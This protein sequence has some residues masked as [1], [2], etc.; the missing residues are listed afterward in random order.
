MAKKNILSGA[1]D[2][3]RN[4]ANRVQPSGG[5]GGAPSGTSSE[6]TK[7]YRQLLNESGRGANGGTRPTGIL[8][9]DDS[10]RRGY[11]RGNAADQ[12]FAGMGRVGEEIQGW[13]GQEE[14]AETDTKVD[15]ALSFLGGLVTGTVSAP[16][17]GAAQI[18]EGVTGRRATEMTDDGL[19]PEEDLGWGQRAA[20]TG[21]GAINI[22]GPMFGGSGEMLKG[23]KNALQYGIGRMAANDGKAWGTRMM[24]NAVKSAT[25]EG[26]E[27]FA[28]KTAKDMAEE[29]AEEF[30]QSPLDEIREGTIDGDW[31]TRAG[32][33]AAM[34]ALG[35]G[36]MSAAGQGINYGLSKLNPP[37]DK[38]GTR[39]TIDTPTP[40]GVLEQRSASSYGFDATKADTMLP[41]ARDA[42]DQAIKDRQT[43]PG[44]APVLQVSSGRTH[45]LNNASIGARVFRDIFYNPDR[46]RSAQMVSDWFGVSLDEMSKIMAS[47]DYDQR[48]HDL[49]EE[50][51]RANKTK[52]LHLGRNPATEKVGRFDVDVDEILT[53]DKAFIDMHPLAYNFV[54]ADVD[55]D[56]I[57]VFL[58]PS[59]TTE[60]YITRRIQNKVKNSWN[61]KTQSYDLDSNLEFED[62]SYIARDLD[63]NLLADAF[64]GA[65]S[66]LDNMDQQTSDDLVERWV[67]LY[68]RLLKGGRG[69]TDS[70]MARFFAT[71]RRDVSRMVNDESNQIAGSPD[72]VTSDLIGSLSSNPV[73]Q[74]QHA[75][76]T[77]TN[78]VVDNFNAF[79][80]QVED[81]GGT[82]D[83]NAQGYTSRG[84]LPS[85]MEGLVTIM[86]RLTNVVAKF[87]EGQKN[88]MF[89]SDGQFVMNAQAQ[90]LI[91]VTNDLYTMLA[92]SV[93]GG[94]NNTVFDRLFAIAIKQTESGGEIIDN[95][96]SAFDGLVRAKTTLD[97]L[98]KTGGNLS[99]G[100]QL[101]LFLEKF[102]DNWN[103]MI[104]PYEEAMKS[105]TTQFPQEAPNASHKKKIDSG[106]VFKNIELVRNVVESF[107][108]INMDSWIDTTDA[109]GIQNMTIGQWLDAYIVGG[110]SDR[111][112]FGGYDP[113]F[114]KFMNLAIASRMAR[115]AGT[116]ASI[117]TIVGDISKQL[118]IL[119]ASGALDP[120][121]RA[122][123]E[124]LV[125]ALRK[126]FDPQI[127]NAV[128]LVSIDNMLTGEWGRALASGSKDEATNA[129]LSMALS[130]K[131][132]EV[133]RMLHRTLELIADGDQIAA[134]NMRLRAMS[135]L[136]MVMHMSTLDRII[137]SEIYQVARDL[138]SIRDATTFSKT[139]DALT[140]MDMSYEAKV[141]AFAIDHDLMS[142]NL[143]VDALN[144]DTN[145]LG[146]SGIS[147]KRKLAE[148][149]Y[150]MAMKASYRNNATTWS[151]IRAHAES[152]K[153]QAN[154]A[155]AIVDLLSDVY[156]ENTMDVL[157]GNIYTSL[158]IANSLKEKGL[159]PYGA[160]ME[161]QQAEI[162]M[163]GAVYSFVDKAMGLAS[164]Q[165]SME[166]LQA[167]PMKL[168]QIIINKDASIRV[169]DQNTQKDCVLTRKMI[170]DELSGGHADSYDLDFNNLDKIFTAFPQ[171]L[172][173]VPPPVLT[174]TMESS[175]S[176]PTVSQQSQ[177]PILNSIINRVGQFN[178]LDRRTSERHVKEGDDFIHNINRKIV[179]SYVMGDNEFPAAI[180]YRSGGFG[181]NA[182]LSKI[183]QKITSVT[184]DVV[185]AIL[186]M[187]TDPKGLDGVNKR[188]AEVDVQG[189]AH[190]LTDI[191][192]I[193]INSDAM[194]KLM[195]VGKNLS[196][197]VCSSMDANFQNI[198][199][200]Q[201]VAAQIRNMGGLSD[202]NRND[203]ISAIMGGDI[204][205][206]GT[207]NISVQS[208]DISDAIGT[209]MEIRFMVDMGI[210]QATDMMNS[211]SDAMSQKTIDGIHSVIDGI[212]SS[213][214]TDDQKKKLKDSLNSP[215]SLEDYYL[216][217]Y[218]FYKG[219]SEK[220]HLLTY[221]D[222]QMTKDKKAQIDRIKDERKRRNEYL[223]E[224]H[225]LAGILYEK[226]LYVDRTYRFDKTSRELSEKGKKDLRD[227]IIRMVIDLN[228]DNNS[229]GGRKAMADRNDLMQ[230]WNSF[231]IKGRLE[232]IAWRSKAYYNTN[233]VN[234]YTNDMR[235]IKRMVIGAREELQ[236]QGRAV[237]LGDF[238]IGGERPEMPKAD[239]ADPI[240]GFMANRCTVNTTRGPAAMTVGVNGAET[241]RL[242]P[243]GLVSRNVHSDVPPVEMSYDMIAAEVCRDN[244][245]ANPQKYMST[246]NDNPADLTGWNRFIGAHYIERGAFVPSSEYDVEN[247]QYV[248]KRITSDVLDDLKNHPDKK[249]LIFD[250]VMSPN[251]ID[252]ESTYDTYNG[253]MNSIRILSEIGM[254]EDTSQ[255][256]LALKTSKSTQQ[257]HRI[258][259]RV[260]ENPLASNPSPVDPTKAQSREELRKRL[261]EA[262]VRYRMNYKTYLMQVFSDQKYKVLGM[263]HMQAFDIAVLL[264]PYYEVMMSDGSRAVISTYD[265]FAGDGSAFM[266]RMDSL[267]QNGVTAVSITPM[268][269]NPKTIASRIGLRV[270]D[271]VIRHNGMPPTDE[272]DE[273]AAEAVRSWDDYGAGKL[274]ASEILSG[275]GTRSLRNTPYVIGDDNPTPYNKFISEVMGEDGTDMGLVFDASS[276]WEK[277]V[278]PESD[279]NQSNLI[280]NINKKL[281]NNG[282][283]ALGTM[284]TGDTPIDPPLIVQAFGTQAALGETHVNNDRQRFIGTLAPLDNPK[285]R[286]IAK[287]DGTSVG[288]VFHESALADAIGWAIRFRQR[289]LI[290]QEVLEKAPS[291]MLANVPMS[292]NPIAYNAGANHIYDT[293]YA[294]DPAQSKEITRAMSMMASGAS[295]RLDHNHI[296]LSVFD[297]TF[298]LPDAA[299]WANLDTVSG[300]GI[301]TSPSSGSRERELFR[302]RNLT[303]ME[304]CDAR[305]VAELKTLVDQKSVALTDVLVLSGVTDR[306]ISSDEAI[307]SVKAF[308]D[309]MSREGTSYRTTAGRG[310]TIALVK[311]TDHTGKT[312][313][314]PLIIEKNQPTYI[315]N[316]NVVDTGLGEIAWGGTSRAQ[317]TPDDPM[318]IKTY[319]A[320]Y[321]SVAMGVPSTS[322]PIV[323]VMIGDEQMRADFVSNWSTYQGRVDDFDM[324]T[325][326]DNL[327]YGYLRFGGSAFWQMSNGTRKRNP[328]LDSLTE[329]EFKGL[330]NND[331]SVWKKVQ[332]GYIKFSN[333]E[334][335]NSLVRTV[336][337]NC[338]LA[339]IPPSYVFSSITLDEGGSN[340]SL[341][342]MDVTYRLVLSG[343]SRT[344]LLRFFHLL[345]PWLCPGV[346]ADGNV[347]KTTA[348]NTLLNEYGQ[349]GI[350]V[351][352]GR[353]NIKLM[354]MDC[355]IGPGL[356]LGHSTQQTRQGSSAR[357]SMQAKNRGGLETPLTGR[358]SREVIASIAARMGNK[359]AYDLLERERISR[360][361]SRIERGEDVDGFEPIS[362]DSVD[363][364][365]SSYVIPGYTP[366]TS[367]KEILHQR[368]MLE[369]AKSFVSPPTIIGLDRK[370]IH[371]YR[372][373][374]GTNDPHFVEKNEIHS[375]RERLEKALNG[376][377]G[378]VSLDWDHFIWAVM[379]QTGMTMNGGN[380]DYRLT[381]NDIKRAVDQ[382]C[383]TLEG[384]SGLLIAVDPNSVNLEDRYQIPMLSPDMASYFMRFEAINSKWGVDD[385]GRPTS[386]GMAAF[387][388]AM[389]NE[390]ITAKGRIEQIAANGKSGHS[391]VKAKLKRDALLKFL[392]WTMHEN[393]LPEMSQHIYGDEYVSDLICNYNEFWDCIFGTPELAEARRVMKEE[394]SR[395]HQHIADLAKLRLAEVN[396][397]GTGAGYTVG[398]KANELKTI[399]DVLDYLT[400]VSQLLAV[401]SPSVMGSNIIDKGIH[402]NLT[403]LALMVGRNIG[404]GPYNTD[405]A[406]DQD[407]VRMAAQNPFLQKVFIGY[408][409]A[410]I[411]GDVYDF[412]NACT[413][414]QRLDEWMDAKR[415]RGNAFTRFSDSVF[416]LMNGG[417]IFMG[418][419]LRNFINYFLIIERDAGHDWWFQKFD[420]TGKTLIESQLTGHNPQDFLL[421]VLTGRN[422]NASFAN[423]QVAMNFALQGD[424]AQRNV[425]SMIYSE[426]IRRHG[427][428]VKFLTSTLVSRFFQY[429]TNQMGRTLQ[430]VLPMSSINYW[431]TK[432]VAENTEIGQA[433]HV[434]DAQVFTDFKR[435]AQN[436]VAHMAPVWVG[437]ILA[438]MVGLIQPPPDEEKWGN[439]EEWL[440]LGHR[441]TLDWELEDILGLSLPI[442]AFLKSCMLGNP[443]IDILVNGIGQAC[444]NN[445]LAKASDIVAMLGDEEGS[446]ISDYESDVERYADA[447]GGAPS[448]VEWLQGKGTA[449]ALTYVGQF[450]TPGFV[451]EFV[452]SPMEHSYNTIWEE[453][454]TG[455][456][457]EE[458]VAG[459]VM[460]TT[461]QDAQIR[462]V[463]RSNPVLGWI[464]DWVTH[465]NTSYTEE[466]MP[467]TKYYDPY[468]MEQVRQYSILDE[469]GNELPYEIQEARIAEI[470][471]IL[472]S[473]DDME[474]LYQSGFYLDYATWDAVGDTIW[475]IIVQLDDNYYQL[476]E[477]GGLNWEVLGEGDTYGL[478]QQRAQEITNAYYDERAYWQSLY[479]DKLMSEPMR[480]KWPVYNRY[481]T[482]YATDDNGDV[483][484]TGYRANTGFLASISPV[485]VAPG[486][487]T[488]PDGTMGYEGDWE[489]ESVAAPGQSTGQRALI[490]VEQGHW[491]YADLE[492]HAVNDDGTGYSKRRNGERSESDLDD[493]SDDDYTPGGGYRYRS[494]GRGGGGGGGGG[495]GY[496]PNI[497]SRLPNSYMPSA[498]TMYSER[499]YDPSYDYL[500]PNFETKGSR[501]AY[502]RS[503]I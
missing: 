220:S 126:L 303:A 236:S 373:K 400:R 382:M 227:R 276:M 311:A 464:L 51:K 79:R 268:S 10:M 158:T 175:G 387:I 337:E 278:D 381:F 380:G 277:P 91:D 160:Q 429:R 467:L 362:G 498:R 469:N 61:E 384:G 412:V 314:A 388:K 316:I 294:F 309:D 406:V 450:I 457:T 209:L 484:A 111:T 150:Q 335:V 24:V 247:P 347:T 371:D 488:E 453:S 20:T 143:L 118:R 108:D 244:G 408:R 156:N 355:V 369:T 251:G 304:L 167:N 12:F 252:Q 152:T 242:A 288:I 6:F 106:D 376:R 292:R 377:R 223:K 360:S 134:E 14:A 207:G 3:L 354:W 154:Y 182:T 366:W 263:D 219:V 177:E 493:D 358:E 72:R 423:G 241:A 497:Y 37:S 180:V 440:I 232:K 385:K 455:A 205:I 499:V 45:S 141:E 389:L 367:Y 439:P 372:S 8:E 290:T 496:S 418:I 120:N 38:S 68:N 495:G 442:G 322:M 237:Y 13:S 188:I 229:D 231:Y 394:S 433:I 392:D 81:L 165:I 65:I 127:A 411:D 48:L 479:Y 332:D 287:Q 466:G 63:D 112:Q 133:Y 274:T 273:V 210:P 228:H 250:P 103:A 473:N 269:V 1:G 409:M 29:A 148:S 443:R 199:A 66:S 102:R 138:D 246:N 364:I 438:S 145:M 341:R 216:A 500:R 349:I 264:T 23:G 444:Y 379:Y 144:T 67:D 456:L 19:I 238:Q 119:Y 176:T 317:F 459:E 480:R 110:R 452:D 84:E 95:I 117:S 267:E 96:S 70:R 318:K 213:V 462:R 489:T 22:I 461:F 184:N 146:A 395:T 502:K 129:I 434:E 135:E 486:T 436:D 301:D 324:F 476:K 131:Y 122:M 413:D 15:D 137:G 258:A 283:V 279:I 295:Y 448:W 463:T 293:V 390:S 356:S 256:G 41:D 4:N 173:L 87:S 351:R 346:D 80:I 296:M 243:L 191:R 447:R 483:Y 471:S 60:G 222:F 446:L 415:A 208:D 136:G 30:I 432:F 359:Q 340:F 458:G 183:R 83:P 56:M 50:N 383:K 221:S 260:E 189:R 132:D 42:Y 97:V 107:E 174:P 363:A 334:R 405:V 445:P 9:A 98:A 325:F 192:N 185:E 166:D 52:V 18:Y 330:Q 350:V 109:P 420:N 249:I 17:T 345:N 224:A 233:I 460:K 218:T 230:L 153:N 35:G 339:H 475:D 54:R 203:A 94:T 32:N 262:M 416:N 157:A 437:M 69:S 190:I 312:I 472:E 361:D 101:R 477:D 386:E 266:R 319:G 76:E 299:T 168:L 197:A 211:V 315:E 2:S 435:A 270:D 281:K 336:V 181:E 93:D 310:D 193:L 342:N 302:G 378:D 481:K 116:N 352:D 300:L 417:N 204:N 421:D 5:G 217:A 414:E 430:T 353:N 393:G 441:V 186:D 198:L 187:A 196:T 115:A 261:I 333:D 142:V 155:R 114:Q 82:T 427:S 195:D 451:K 255:E 403:N 482:T 313:Y 44:S 368:E 245:T 348:G 248:T 169:V 28:W 280:N 494:Y 113:E 272:V 78:E 178:G 62:F 468:V 306:Q 104:G 90:K 326:M 235:A 428:C 419:Q 124:H 374:A 253:S 490:P 92:K 404:V 26:G 99:T 410:M 47:S 470:I 100:D 503:D 391:S 43:S 171:L 478:G 75:I 344:D 285:K 27:S 214:L 121:D 140:S 149:Q 71:V 59:V 201:F 407:A 305:S 426:M 128:G 365:V 491:D 327:W 321:K 172:S 254:L 179:A 370:P 105:A 194:L 64:R 151:G 454:E 485:K 212:E 257:E 284:I 226:I 265:V 88:P 398:M 77:A 286:D 74:F 139:F 170:L 234:A 331:A 328:L 308:L 130:G 200:K 298:P 465:P 31:L 225:R 58:D 46:G 275:V 25:R 357:S 431:F 49:H 39:K 159:T 147:G 297:P 215:R 202:E 289:L 402:T 501:E 55:G 338:R 449:A 11:K 162:N 53:G 307:A 399:N 422:D 7:S 291:Q 73:S 239:Y 206:P 375:A 164:G 163:N 474:A 34:G 36:I 425:V 487:M 123:A 401:A 271:L 492:S 86:Y 396:A 240:I 329:E 85:G 259:D 40:P 33:A 89:R 57:N 343:M 161:Y 323:N 21:S 125:T 320:V 16:F 282:I 397:Y 424:M